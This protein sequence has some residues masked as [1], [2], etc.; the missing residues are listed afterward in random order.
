[1]KARGEVRRSMMSWLSM[2]AF[3]RARPADLEAKGAMYESI[4][5]RRQA[6]RMASAWYER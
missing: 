6:R 3:W 4:D 5:A 2:R 1:M